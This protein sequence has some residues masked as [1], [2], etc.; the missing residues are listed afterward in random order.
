M[1]NLITNWDFET[2]TS[3]WTGANGGTIARSSTQFNTG[4]WSLRVTTA[5]AN[6]GCIVSASIAVTAVTQ[7]TLL[8]WARC[9]STE[10]IGL[11]WNEYNISDVYQAT[12]EIT[13]SCPANTWTLLTGNLTTGA[14]SVKVKPFTSIRNTSPDFYVDSYNIDLPGG[15]VSGAGMLLGVG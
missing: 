4:A 6:D 9:D 1:A 14:T 5:A 11:G 8:C 15:G 3:G 13:V 12:Q 7:Y 10:T 2:D